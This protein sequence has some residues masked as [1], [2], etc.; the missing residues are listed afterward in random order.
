MRNLDDGQ[1]KVHN[2]FVL[3]RS[4]C[5]CDNNNKGAKRD[6]KRTAHKE[7]SVL[8]LVSLKYHFGLM[9]ANGITQVSSDKKWNCRSL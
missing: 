1:L 2:S 5:V 3:D 4:I 8:R 9:L 7:N 6:L